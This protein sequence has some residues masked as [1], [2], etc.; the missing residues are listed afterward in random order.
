MAAEE[1]KKQDELKRIERELAEGTGY[2]E[3]D[4]F[5][6]HPAFQRQASPRKPTVEGR[7]HPLLS[8]GPSGSFSNGRG[9]S[10]MLWET[11]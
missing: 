4:R 6:L 9:Q 7:G 10:W 2:R 8:R 5:V 11:W 3:S 1:K